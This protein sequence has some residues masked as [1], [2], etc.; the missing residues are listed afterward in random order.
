MNGQKPL[1]GA[2][3]RLRGFIE[4]TPAIPGIVAVFRWTFADPAI[5]SGLQVPMMLKIIAAQYHRW[6]AGDLK[7][8]RSQRMETPGPS[9]DVNTTASGE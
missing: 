4:Q 7:A 1:A 9:G 2:P 3:P 5:S 6:F 8:L